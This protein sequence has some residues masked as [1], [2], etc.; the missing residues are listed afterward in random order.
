MLSC[1]VKKRPHSGQLDSGEAPRLLVW[2]LTPMPS[3]DALADLAAEF[4]DLVESTYSI[5]TVSERLYTPL[6]H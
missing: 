4:G 3:E 1:L 2:F 5:D 6:V